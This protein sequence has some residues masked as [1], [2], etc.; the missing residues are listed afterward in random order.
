[1]KL[2]DFERRVI[3]V[4]ITGDPEEAVLRNQLSAVTVQDRDYTGIGVFVYLGVEEVAMRAKMTNRF[5]ETT[6]TAFLTHPDL[7][8]GAQ[9]MLWFTENRMSCLECVT[10]EGQWPGDESK[11]EAERLEFPQ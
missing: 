4:M 3:D 9:A 1:M 8:D 2:S 6:P 11:F 7:T 10:V 5:I